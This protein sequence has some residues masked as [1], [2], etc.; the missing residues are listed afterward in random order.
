MAGG[1][2]GKVL[3]VDLSA[4]EEERFR[5][6]AIDDETYRKYGSGYGLAAY[7]IWGAQPGGL[8]PL[9]PDNVL[10]F[11]SALLTNGN[12]VFNGRWMVAGKS[13]LTGTWGDANCGGNFA[14]AIKRT[15]FDGIFFV[16]RSD[17][18][19]YL[20]IDGNEISLQDASW[21]WGC[22]D[23]VETEQELQQ[24]HGRDFR[25]ACVGS[26]GEKLTPIA[27]IVNDGGRL[28]GRSGLGALM[29]SKNLKAVCLRGAL[30]DDGLP[31]H[32]AAGVR[33]STAQY[34]TDLADQYGEFYYLLHEAGTAATVT[35]SGESGDSPL[36]NWLGVASRDFPINRAERLSGGSVVK[37]QTETYG[38]YNCP[39]RCGG[40][41]EVPGNPLLAHTHRPE[42]ETLCAFGTQ[43]LSDDLHAV[44]EINERLNRAGIDTISTGTTLH[45]AFEAFERGVITLADTDNY[46]LTWGNAEAALEMVKKIVDAEGIGDILRQGV[47]AAAEHFGQGSEAYAMHAGGQELPMHDCR[48]NADGPDA[49]SGG[50]GLGV[51]YEVEP[52]PGRHTSWCPEWSCFLEDEPRPVLTSARYHAHSNRYFA[53]GDSREERGRQLMGGSCTQDLVN[54][55]GLCSF[56]LDLGIPVPLV[57]WAN[58]TTGWIRDDGNPLSF[59]DYL[60]IGRRVKTLRHCFNLRE[61]EELGKARMPDRARGIPPLDAGPNAGSPTSQQWDDAEE[62]YYRAMGW[63]DL[64]KT[65]TELE[66]PDVRQVLF[67][68]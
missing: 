49:V 35:R 39:L 59:T 8:G 15:G 38:C 34:L 26:G 42:Y 12:A 41:C 36:K 21:L 2:L 30:T 37:Y 25:V 20:L 29:G 18:P 31:V 11:M 22:Y 55:L 63:D 51:A 62:D 61:S 66:M 28:A 33:A 7:L 17:E 56:G 5:T 23:A 65:L 54:V 68:S 13:P 16:G 60:E 46:A 3:W 52:T 6:Q 45:W 1:Y 58:R 24:L 32:D 19:V 44:F 67:P 4:N 48:N 50:L 40:I 64:S 27:G 43:L 47:K 9:D 57:D 53:T 10:A 14:P